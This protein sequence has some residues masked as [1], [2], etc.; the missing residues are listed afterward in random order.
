MFNL[1]GIAY[2]LLLLLCIG[3][4]LADVGLGLSHVLVQDL[5]TV[6]D[7]RLSGVEHLADLPGH[8]RLTATRRSEQHDAL[9]VLTTW[10]DGKT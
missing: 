7:L 8:E 6:D 3:E 5:G 1:R 10:N 2:P 4:Q 9:H